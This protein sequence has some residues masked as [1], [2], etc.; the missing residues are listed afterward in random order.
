[1]KLFDQGRDHVIGL[2]RI[3]LGFLFFVHGAARLF[4]IFGAKAAAEA[5][6]WP[7]WWASLIQF[8]GGALVL[9]G[10]GTRAAA[11][12]CSGS[13]AY[14]YFTAHQ[15]ANLLPIANGGELS[16][17]FCWAFLLIAFLGN[18]KWALEGVLKRQPGRVEAAH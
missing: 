13:M 14:A 8:L 15:S 17:L 18:G 9:L 16:V 11:I 2:F 4:G 10:I 1:M 5:F 3:V 6:A 7:G 12:I